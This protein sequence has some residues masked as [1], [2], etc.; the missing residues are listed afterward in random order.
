ML[1]WYASLSFIVLYMACIHSANGLFQ[2]KNPA[3]VHQIPPYSRERVNLQ[4]TGCDGVGN[5][6][7]PV[8]R[9]IL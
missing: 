4:P 2:L 1:V 7:T 3:A 9:T 6:I 8:E 5:T